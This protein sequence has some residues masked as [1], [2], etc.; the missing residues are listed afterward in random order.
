MT[1]ADRIE[2]FLD[3]R[4]A[5]EGST[6]IAGDLK[7]L[8]R[9]IWNRD[10]VEYPLEG[11]VIYLARI[12]AGL[13]ENLI[14]NA[15][16]IRSL[17]ATLANV[18]AE[19]VRVGDYVRACAACLAMDLAITIRDQL[20]I[21][22]NN[23]KVVREILTED[24]PQFEPDVNNHAFVVA[25]A[26]AAVP[27]SY[28]DGVETGLGSYWADLSRHIRE[29]RD[30]QDNYRNITLPKVVVSLKRILGSPAA[31]ETLEAAIEQEF[32]KAA[33][34]KA[35]DVAG[36]AKPDRSQQGDLDGDRPPR[37]TEEW[38]LRLERL[39]RTLSEHQVK[40][41]TIVINILKRKSVRRTTTALHGCDKSLSE[42]P[43]KQV[44][45]AATKA[46]ILTNRSNAKSRGYGLPEWD[47]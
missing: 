13:R 30:F 45:A 25:V 47:W 3:L 24:S 46:G 18:H 32:A 39:C 7:F 16:A 15:K 29:S 35:G 17:E 8:A 19:P 21:M 1:I 42:G 23:D 40:H 11:Q 41:L 38:E 6:S 5:Y 10:N 12:L 33:V 2:P 37:T 27:D 26:L 14:A 44:L 20:R 4:A 43:L 22:F 36:P 9:L 28:T 31:M 34:K